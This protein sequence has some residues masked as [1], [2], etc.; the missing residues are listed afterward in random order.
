MVKIGLLVDEY[1]G[2]KVGGASTW[3]NNFLKMFKGHTKYEVVPIYCYE[4]KN[5]YFN[6]RKIRYVNKNTLKEFKP[7]FKDINIVINCLWSTNKVLKYIKVP[8]ISVIHSLIFKE[9]ESNYINFRHNFQDETIGLSAY[10]VFVSKSDQDY[11]IKKYPNINKPT[12]FIYNVYVPEYTERQYRSIDTIGYI[13]RFVPRKRPE[14]P[15]M[16]LD[17]INRLDV[18]CFFMGK[19]TDEYWQDLNKKYD[20]LILCPKSFNE[21]DKNLFFDKVGIGSFTSIYE[22]F[23]YSLCEFIDRGIPVIVADI[24]GPTEIIEGFRDY[25]YPYEVHKD[26][27]KDIESYS[28]TLEHVLSL[29]HEER[30]QNALRAREIL[31]RFRPEVIIKKWE[32]LLVDDKVWNSL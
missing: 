20:N 30:K 4:G 21:Y 32:E 28:K 19:H 26:Q 18:K 23:G 3:T 2:N 7:V 31:D 9:I 27:D 11:F 17:K 8:I 22:P 10:V 25:V 24:D 14:L 29:S 12:S 6:E 16:A 15:I 5:V 1:E 13:G